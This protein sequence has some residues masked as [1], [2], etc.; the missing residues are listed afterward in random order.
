MSWLTEGDR[1]K[2]REALSG[3]KS[4]VR[5]IFFT[6]TIGCETC[7]P[8]RQLID[9][10]VL[11]SDELTF[12]EYNLVLDVE[13]AREYGVD[14]APAIAVVGEKDTGVRFIGEPAGH[15]FASLIDAILLVS[16]GDSGLSEES[17]ALLAAVTTPLHI[18]VFVTP[19]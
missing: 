12:E 7:L 1:Q 4:P 15:E 8:T 13:K 10:V 14:K 5:L 17:Q 19:T 2:V 6:Q 9:E 16:S 3:M 11:L 18:Q